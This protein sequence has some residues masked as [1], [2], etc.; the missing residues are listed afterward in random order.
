MGSAPEF[1]RPAASL[2][3]RGCTLAAPEQK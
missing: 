2:H 3:D 1:Q